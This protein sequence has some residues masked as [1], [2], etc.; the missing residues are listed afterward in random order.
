MRSYY[1]YLVG[2]LFVFSVEIYRRLNGETVTAYLILSYMNTL[3]IT[4]VIAKQN[5]YDVLVLAQKITDER[6]IK[7]A[8]NTGKDY[9]RLEARIERLEKSVHDLTRD[10]K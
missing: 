9:G 8:R 6:I 7:F 3:A 5:S 4:S 2:I 10:K 1:I